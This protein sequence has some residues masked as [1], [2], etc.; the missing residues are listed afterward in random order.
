MGGQSA[1]TQDTKQNATNSATTDQT[2]LTQALQQSLSNTLAN[3]MQATNQT[4]NQATTAAT[5]QANNQF[6]NAATNQANNQATNQLQQTGQAQT[7]TTN[8]WEAA[9]P[10]VSGLMGQLNPL[11]GTSGTTPGMDSAFAA[12]QN[13]FAQGN[14]YAAK[15]G[16]VTSNL[17]GGGGATNQ[18]G[19]VNQNYQDYAKRLTPTANGANIGANSGL[20]PYL[21]NIRTDVTNQVNP[22]FAAAGRDFSGANMQALGRGISQGQAPVIAGQYNTDVANSRSAADSLYGAGNTTAGINMGMGQQALGNQ[23]AGIGNVPGALDAG[24]YGANQTLALEQLKQQIPE[25]NL[26]LLAQIGVP[27]TYPL[28]IYERR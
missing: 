28:R 5:N 2:S 1:Q 18:A 3:Q 22:M 27:G 13:N 26:G 15:I 21:D 25:K 10:T 6:T 12:L 17:L 8:P 4:N 11:I 23:Q 19:P 14:P 16:D 20:L 7:S 9:L 24:N